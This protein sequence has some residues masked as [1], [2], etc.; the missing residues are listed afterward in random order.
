MAAAG[1]PAHEP[2][3]ARAAVTRVVVVEDHPIFRDGVVQCLAA[4]P[5]F[6]V[7]GAFASGDVDL[8]ALG[9]AGPDLVLMDIELPGASG[10]DAT[11]RIRAHFPALRVV[12]LTAFVD[13]DLLLGAVQAGAA[14]YVL[15]HTPAPELVRTLR[16]IAAGE[17]FLTPALAARVLR[18]FGCAPAGELGRGP[19]AELSPREE[20]VLKLLATG[21]TNRQIAARL[22]VSEETVKSHVAAIFRKLEVSD[23]TRAAVLAVKAG[24]VEI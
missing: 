5:D 4:E 16:A 14:G 24:L 3:A 13:P 1:P 9:R 12:M 17:H 11:R 6:T 20:E 21:E 15:K 2:R 23:R 18:A 19:F 8:G 22:S 10:I 7:V